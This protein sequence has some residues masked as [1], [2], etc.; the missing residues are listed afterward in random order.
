MVQPDL[1]DPARHFSV[2]R[3]VFEKLAR[4]WF[5]KCC[6]AFGAAFLVARCVFWLR[7]VARD[8]GHQRSYNV[9]AT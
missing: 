8:Y 5:Q 6:A 3:G 1:T 4:I 7:G 9:V 2:A